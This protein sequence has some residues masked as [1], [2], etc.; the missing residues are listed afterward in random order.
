MC[1]GIYLCVGVYVCVCVYI[2]ACG[3]IYKMNNLRQSLNALN[4]RSSDSGATTSLYLEAF[5]K[6]GVFVMG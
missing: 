3:Y 2:H 6:E 5:L 1:M 4:G